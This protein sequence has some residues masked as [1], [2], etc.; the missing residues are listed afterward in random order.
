[1]MFPHMLA[2]KLQV[3]NDQVCKLIQKLP[4]WMYFNA[5]SLG[6][7]KSLAKE[8]EVSEME[9]VETKTK[10]NHMGSV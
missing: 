6:T 5:V 4:S 1:M 8:R 10:K 9:L 2:R 7:A 3:L